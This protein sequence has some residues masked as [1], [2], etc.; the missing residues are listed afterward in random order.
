MTRVSPPPITDNL[1][2]TD[3]LK[4]TI[5]WTLFFNQIYSGD[6]G[7]DWTPQFVNLTT[8]GTPTITGRVYRIGTSLAYFSLT[9]TP[10]TSTTSVAGT[11]YIDNLPVQPK[12]GGFCVAVSGGLGD[13][14]GMIDAS[15]NRVYVPSWSAV[16]IPLVVIGVCEIQ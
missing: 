13:G 8:V 12:T 16:T 3:T 14:P 5:S 11:T 1:F 10:S 4:P 9:I 7:S 6:T 15:T 2:E